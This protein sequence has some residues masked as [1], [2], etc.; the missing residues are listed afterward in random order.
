MTN[1]FAPQYSIVCLDTDI[2]KE[3]GK[4]SFSIHNYVY[5]SCILLFAFS[6]YSV[7]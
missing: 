4:M 7:V 3:M 6:I 1:A 2:A 5:G